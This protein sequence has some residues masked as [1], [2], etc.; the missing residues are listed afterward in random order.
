MNTNFFLLP[1]EERYNPEYDMV[2]EGPPVTWA[3][4][5]LM[6]VVKQQQVEIESL[7]ERIYNLEAKMVME[8]R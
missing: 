3:E 5:N 8:E 1:I 7:K 4:Y 2:L 6:K